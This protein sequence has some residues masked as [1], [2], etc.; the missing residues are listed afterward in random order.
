MNLFLYTCD[1]WQS[2]FVEGNQWSTLKFSNDIVLE[3][4]MYKG[5]YPMCTSQV[6][7][8][9]C[10]LQRLMS[11]LFVR[12]MTQGKHADSVGMDCST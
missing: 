4:I 11:L 10:I 8:N 6:M 2:K 7:I 5:L 3:I 1:N 9:E 12:H